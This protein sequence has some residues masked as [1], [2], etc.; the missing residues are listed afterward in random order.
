MIPHFGR[1]HLDCF[2]AL[3]M[4]EEGLLG[5]HSGSFTT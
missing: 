2:A 1:R 4:T 5:K 3:A